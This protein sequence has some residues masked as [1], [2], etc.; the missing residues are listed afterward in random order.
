MGKN[1]GYESNLQEHLSDESTDSLLH[2]N[3]LVEA[4]DSQY[5]GMLRIAMQSE[6]AMSPLGLSFEEGDAIFITKMPAEGEKKMYG[7][8]Y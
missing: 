2:S 3:H 5:Q 4:A 6:A 1:L 8:C 7:I